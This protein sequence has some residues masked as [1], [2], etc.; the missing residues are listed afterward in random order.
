[1]DKLL[2]FMGLGTGIYLGTP[3]GITKSVEHLGNTMHFLMSLP[4]LA[5]PKSY[6]DFEPRQGKPSQLLCGGSSG[7]LKG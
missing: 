4:Q 1:M 2:V 6:R 3:S 5:K 7:T